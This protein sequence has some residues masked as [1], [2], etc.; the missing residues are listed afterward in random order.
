ME[1]TANL[2]FDLKI[3]SGLM[4]G[5]GMLWKYFGERK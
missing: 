4:H 5:L 1:E 2:P 3:V